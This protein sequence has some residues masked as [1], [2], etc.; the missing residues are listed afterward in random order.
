[1]VEL[2]DAVDPEISGVPGLG[3]DFFEGDVVE[4][5]AIAVGDLELGP[6]GREE[7][8]EGEDVGLDVD[9]EEVF[10]IELVEPGGG[11]GIPAPA[12]FAFVA[13]GG[14]DV[15]G[16][17][18]GFEF[19]A[20]GGCGGSGAVNGVEQ[21]AKFP[22]VVDL[23]ELGA[24][25]GHPDGGMGV[26]GAIFADAGDV[27]FDVA[28]IPGG[29]VEGGGE[30]PD[31]AVIAV[32]EAVEGGLHGPAGA[33]GIGAAGENGPALGEG[34]DLAFRALGGAEGG[35]VVKEG[36]QVPFAV[37][38][39]GVNGG[40]KFVSQC[41]AVGGEVV[42]AAGGGDRGEIEEDAAEEEGE[43]DTFAFTFMAD[44]VHA[45]IP[46]AA[47]NEGESVG[48]GGGGAA[49]S[50]DTVIVEGGGFV[51]DTG[52]VID[53]FFVV[54]EGASF[55]EGDAFVEDAGIAGGG[56]VAAGDIGQPEEVIG[57][58]GAD[59]ASDGGVP[60]VLDVAFAELAGGGGE[61]VFAGVPGAFVRKARESWSW[62]RKPKAPPD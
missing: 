12:A 61:E 24:G 59:A 38:G 42:I 40:G 13:G 26:L 50:A 1:M 57:D 32:D 48:A 60:P 18:V 5:V 46:I 58:L 7:G 14:I 49:D 54:G 11:T 22:S 25:H 39:V 21:A 62:S 55:E 3:A 27:A 29:G 16:E 2:L 34:I 17:D 53:G 33:L 35:A 9:A 30:E 47:A 37:P 23:A 51:A 20:G 43:P 52:L 4:G 36:A 45:V 19:I 56:D 31:E 8:G 28:G 6:I 44:A 15:G 41:R 10:D